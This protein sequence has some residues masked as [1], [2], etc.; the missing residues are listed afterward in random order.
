MVN[1]YA[2]LVMKGLR[3][4]DQVPVQWRSDVQAEVERRQS[5]EN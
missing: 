3:T 5:E 4:I 1:L 2:D